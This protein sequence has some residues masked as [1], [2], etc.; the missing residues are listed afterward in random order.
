MQQE[1][2][3]EEGETAIEYPGLSEKEIAELRERRLTEQASNPYYIKPS[4]KPSSRRTSSIFSSPETPKTA[5]A[6]ERTIPGL[7]SSDKYLRQQKKERN[8]E[9]KRKNKK[10]SKKRS[11][12]VASDEEGGITA[13]VVNR[14]AGEMPEGATL[15]DGAGS[16]H[17][18]PYR[19]LNI[20]I[21]SPLR[22][23]ERL[24]IGVHRAV[25]QQGLAKPTLSSPTDAGKTAHYLR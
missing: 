12:A 4:T 10:T 17:D 25:Q 21:Q 24:H 13:H 19:A 8:E 1:E 11:G 23:E 14:D 20:D 16:D 22:P 15:S 18:D 2:V 9:V 6:E 7:T 5:T 3:P